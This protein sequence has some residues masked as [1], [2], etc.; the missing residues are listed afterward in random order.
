[1]VQVSI[2]TEKETDIRL[3]NV[4]KE[5][6]FRVY[7]GTYCFEEFTSAE[8]TQRMDGNAL[9]LIRDNDAWSQL[10]PSTNGSNE[11][12][13]IFSFHFDNASDNS[14]FVGWLASLLKKELGTGVFVTCGQ[15]SNRGGIFDYWGCPA[16]LGQRAVSVIQGLIEGRA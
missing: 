5:A 4:I 3:R 15:N 6:D 7:A 11:L 10:V 12:F 14:G 13:T 2:E 16:H 8:L 9:A 1:M